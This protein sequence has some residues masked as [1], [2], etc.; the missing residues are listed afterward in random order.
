[1][2]KDYL[3]KGLIAAPYTPMKED[4]SINLPKIREYADKI[5]GFGCVSGVYICGSTGEYASTTVEER[6][7]IAEAWVSYAEGRF[8][9]V[10]H[11]GSNCSKD[12]A[13]LAAHAKAIG[14]D[15][16]ASIA[17]NYFRPA[18]VHDLIMFF[19][20]IAEAAGD[21]PFYYYNF[22]GMSG[23]KL[24]VEEFLTEGKKI[25]PNLAGVKFT[26]ND[27][28]EMQKIVNLQDGA[29]NILNGYDEM[30]IAGLICGAQGA[31]G[32]TYNYVPRIYQNVIDA[33]EAGDLKA[34]KK[35]QYEAVRIVDVLIAHGGG[36]RAGKAFMKLAGV[37][38]GQCRY[39]IGPVSDE[40]MKCIEEE[41]RKTLFFE[42]I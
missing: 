39:P 16:V 42:Y 21:L 40:E 12:S 33:L 41:L 8:K 35:W 28:F 2:N 25:M 29:F 34:A 24:S 23:V 20:P 19:K 27:F 30:L 31:V 22:P 1:M 4:G 26:H 7:A 6:K 13:E 15:A 3:L 14:A 10:V 11:V 17:P 9:V 37:D 18:S 32:S 36:V 38:C 5:A